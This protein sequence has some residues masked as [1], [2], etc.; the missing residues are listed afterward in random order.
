[1]GAR[2]A[3]VVMQLALSLALVVAA[4]LFARTFLAL[5][6]REAG[7]E[8]DSVLI[9]NV[10]VQRSGVSAAARPELFERLRQAAAGVA[11][12]GSAAASFT[13]PL[14]GPG[15][16]TGIAVQADSA[17]TRRE[18]SSW[19]N[20][21]SPGWFETYG[22]RRVAGRDFDDRD[23]PGAPLVAVVNRAFARRFLDG[24]AVGASFRQAGPRDRPSYEVVGIVEDAVYRSL[25]AEMAPTMY[26]PLAQQTDLGTTVAVGVRVAGGAPTGIARAL[27]E[28]L[29]RAEPTAALSFRTLR[30]QV[31]ASVTQERLLATLSVFFGGLALLL[32]GV[33]L[34]AVTSYAVNARR[35][36]IGIRMAL[37]ATAAGVVR[38]IL[39][40]VAWLVL[41]GV[42]IGAALS[43]WSVRYIATLLYG[44]QPFDPPTF[45]AAAVLLGAVGALAGWLPARRA[46]R[47]DP[48][49]ALREG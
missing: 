44:L 36:E 4:G 18:R 32:S 13:T 5:T 39:R 49:I 16:N 15:W 33:G 28:A 12:A 38:M 27:S 8:R 29:H 17:L 34:Y 23:Q 9:A 11:G 35:T 20:A 19:V 40:R 24:E 25:R 47:L 43:V 14:A 3:L 7:F 1:L 21:V 6:T 46:A 42:A 2:Q 10:D 22:V 30:E 45:A 31:S 37:G 48:M 41:A 26:V